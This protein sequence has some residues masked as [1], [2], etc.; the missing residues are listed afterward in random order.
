MRAGLLLLVVGCRGG[1]G[2][3][4]RSLGLGGGGRGGRRMRRRS[5]TQ[6][7]ACHA[8]D[9]RRGSRDHR[10]LGVLR[11]RSEG[12]LATL[13]GEE[14]PAPARAANRETALRLVQLTEGV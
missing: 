11:G 6:R 14:D 10:D 8:A 12:P 5:E 9:E 1:G 3:G 4:G 13:V 7:R 2:L